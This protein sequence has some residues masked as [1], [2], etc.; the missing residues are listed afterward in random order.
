ML[1]L[2]D[3]QPLRTLPSLHR[4]TAPEPTGGRGSPPPPTP[5]F[6]IWAVFGKAV[7]RPRMKTQWVKTACVHVPRQQH[8]SW[9]APAPSPPHCTMAEAAARTPAAFPY[10]GCWGH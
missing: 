2:S 6:L 4:L 7:E 5:V 10:L 9:A 8:T 3:S 1:L